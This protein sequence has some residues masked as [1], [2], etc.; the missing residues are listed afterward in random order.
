MESNLNQLKIFPNPTVTLVTVVY[1]GE[2]FIRE[3]IESVV[4]QLCEDVEY[5]VIDGASTDSTVDIIREYDHIITYWISEPD[6]GIYDAWNK[7]IKVSRG[8]FISFLG[9][10]DLLNPG[11][12]RSYI[13][14]IK[15]APQ[16]D[17]WSSKA[18]LGHKDS[19]IFGKPWDWTSFKKYMTVAHVGSMHSRD[20]YLEFGLYDISYNI[21]G[22]YE[23]LLRCGGSLKAGYLDIVTVVMGDD[24]ISNNQIMLTLKE[25]QRAK[26]QTRSRSQIMS[27]IDYCVAICK[28]YIKNSIKFSKKSC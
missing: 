21:V 26:V 3:C 8:S 18:A 4:P 10:D 24:G 28:W 6:R 13:D 1:N 14:N 12:L 5:I 25:T 19:I 20:L 27:A 23:F 2:R 11:A 16:I 15:S 7:A 22:D 9:A 17:Y